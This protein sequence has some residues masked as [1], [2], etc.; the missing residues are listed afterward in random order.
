VT[1][2]ITGHLGPGDVKIGVE[3]AKGLQAA[4]TAVGGKA[5]VTDETLVANTVAAYLNTVGGLGGR[6]VVLAIHATDKTSGT[7]NSQ[8]AQTCADLAEDKK[9]FA[10]VSS[11]VGGNDALAAC[12]AQHHVPLVE[13]NFWPYDADAYSRWGPYLY[14]PARATPER[15]TGAYV[16]GLADEGFFAKGAKVGLVRYEAPQ[17]ARMADGIKK[18]LSARGITLT[19]EASVITP[20]AI[21]DFGAMN[22]Q[23]AS[24]VLRFRSKGI[25]HVIFAEY[26]GIVP[27]FLLPQSESQGYRPRWGFSSSDLPNTQA[28]NAPKIQ[29]RDALVVGWMPPNDISERDDHRGGN[30]ALCMSLLRKAGVGTPDRLYV[31]STC[32]SLLFLKAALDRASALTPPALQASVESLG[33]SYDSAFAWSA[34]FGP[35]RHDGAAGVQ[36]AKWDDGC[37]CFHPVGALKPLP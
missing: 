5:N 3:V 36:D 30:A 18:R 26:N 33:T 34:K 23:L 7:W 21:A 22:A 35:G 24:A 11:T 27:F 29:L 2:A 32:D 37:A 8:G 6:R 4:I 1:G 12:L 31:Q 9:V 17:F 25:D 10:V 19:D 14:Q 28:G 13:Q 15:W 20:Q 16:D